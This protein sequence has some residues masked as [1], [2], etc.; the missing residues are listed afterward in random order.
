[1][2]GRSSSEH[3]LVLLWGSGGL[4]QQH[5]GQMELSA[6]P[7]SMASESSEP[8][9]EQTHGPDASTSGGPGSA[10]PLLFTVLARP[11]L[12]DAGLRELEFP[13]VPAEALLQPG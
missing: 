4:W 1:M 12:W 11:G 3:L 2:E 10:E 7:S 9:G 13:T 8:P 5:R 6:S